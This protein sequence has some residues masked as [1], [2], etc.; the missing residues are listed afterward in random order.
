MD[1]PRQLARFLLGRRAR[2]DEVKAPRDAVPLRLELV[3]ELSRLLVRVALD[4]NLPRRV[5]LL[6]DLL[7]DVALRRLVVPALL[8]VQPVLDAALLGPEAVVAELGVDDVLRL[9]DLGPCRRV[10]ENRLAVPGD[11][12]PAR[13]EI[14][15]ELA[16]LGAQVAPK[17]VEDA[18]GVF[19]LFEFDVEPPVV[20][21]HRH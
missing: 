3:G 6:E 13:F 19:L 2:D 20:G 14:L 5:A 4:A 11:G 15:G 10:D 12:Q 16:C 1:A 9:L 21:C 7:V 8:F 18:R 17:P